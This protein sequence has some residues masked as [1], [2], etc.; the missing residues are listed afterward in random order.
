MPL[1]RFA[2]LPGLVFACAVSM[3]SSACGGG[4]GG[5]ATATGRSR[6]GPGP[7]L[8]AVD[9][10]SVVKADP[11]SALPADWHSRAFMQIFVR[12]YQ[13]SDGDGI[14]DLR[15]LTQR[16]DYLKELG[17]G[18]LWLMPVTKS[19]DHDHGYAV[20]DYRNTESQYGSLT[21]FEELLRQAHAR[22][23]G[24]IVDYVMNHSAAENPLFVNSK[25]GSS[26]P[27]RDW[28]L[29]LGRSR[30]AGTSTATTRGAAARATTTS[31]RSGTRCPISTC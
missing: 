20:A 23:I 22:G 3:L 26:N 9:V 8:P 28:Y 12:S 5:D 2:P 11:G 6:A 31:R 25:A 21:D 18:G 15:G 27:Y 1:H 7:T 14:G 16:L 29:W 30:A 4:G 17:V 13:D 10:S 24:V 19:Q